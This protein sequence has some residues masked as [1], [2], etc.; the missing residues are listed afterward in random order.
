M[1]KWICLVLALCLLLSLTACANKEKDADGSETA[2]TF[3]DDLGNEITVDRPQQV[4]CLTE[5]LAQLWNLAGGTQTVAAVTDQGEPD[6]QRLS[7]CQPE[8]VLADC[9]RL[10]DG[11]K[12]SK[13]KVA[14]F[15]ITTFDDYLRVLQICTLITGSQDNYDLYGE[16]VR[17][18][19][20]NAIV[21]A[22]GTRP[23]VLCIRA[24]GS[25]CAAL[26]SEG[27]VL[28]E[29]LFDLDCVNI[30]DGDTVLPEQ[31][32]PEAI[33]QADPDYIFLVE[34][35]AEAEQMPES[36]LLSSPEWESLRAVRE[37][38][39]FLLDAAMYGRAPNAAWGDAYEALAN[40]LYPTDQ[41]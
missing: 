14:C 41:E 19:I 35:A 38:R 33:A 26:C 18:Q 40:I 29:M 5:G 27:N 21:R 24:S 23:A 8:L 3:T 34:D 11:L 2:V 4:A 20:E 25:G 37:K 9:D 32:T 16:P 10:P 17:A 30:A 39:F 1:K 22:D 28:G 13:L 36:T 15:R 6:L 12:A 31:L 7:D